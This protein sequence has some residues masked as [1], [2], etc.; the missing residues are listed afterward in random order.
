M[1]KRACPAGRPDDSNSG[2]L[3]TGWASKIGEANP[4]SA[5]INSAPVAIF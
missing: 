3:A 1:R 4:V 5:A 2:A